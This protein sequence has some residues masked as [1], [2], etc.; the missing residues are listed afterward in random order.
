MDPALHSMVGWS[1]VEKRWKKKPLDANKSCGNGPHPPNP[2][3]PRLCQIIKGGNRKV[4]SSD[5]PK[6]CSS[7]LKPM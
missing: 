5:K 6:A 2:P 3:S 1:P 7:S 4:L